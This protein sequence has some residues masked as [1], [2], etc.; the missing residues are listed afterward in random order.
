MTMFNLMALPGE[1]RNEIYD[2]ATFPH[3]DFVAIHHC[4]TP[5]DVVSTVLKSPIFRLSPQI[6]TEALVRLF[7]TKNFDF[8]D[9][10]SALNF[11]SWAGRYGELLIRDVT[12]L[13]LRPDTVVDDAVVSAIGVVLIRALCLGVGCCFLHVMC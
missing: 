10:A 4:T 11:L 3:H 6:R 8:S 5:R 13:G 9:Y 1:I 7:E 2:H 12:F